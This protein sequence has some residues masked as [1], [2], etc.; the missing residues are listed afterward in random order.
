MAEAS[1]SS[2]LRN[3]VHNPTEQFIKQSKRVRNKIRVLLHIYRLIEPYTYCGLKINLGFR[4]S[5]KG[6]GTGWPTRCIVGGDFEALKSIP[7][8]TSRIVEVV[9]N[10][11]I[12]R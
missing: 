12:A 2:Q 4:S 1:C 5:F 10:E 3:I 7:F 11:R 6:L 8:M 9:T